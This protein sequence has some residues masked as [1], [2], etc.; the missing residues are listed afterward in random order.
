[1]QRCNAILF[2][3]QLTVQTRL[4]QPFVHLFAPI[5]QVNREWESIPAGKKARNLCIDA[6]ATSGDLSDLKKWDCKENGQNPIRTTNKESLQSHI[7]PGS[8]EP[9]HVSLDSVHQQ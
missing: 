7:V 6:T 8:T 3:E 4:H 1:M 9:Q 5:D 2:V